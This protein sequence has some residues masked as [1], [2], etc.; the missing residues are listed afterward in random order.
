MLFISSS[1][2]TNHPQ[3]GL[4]STGILQRRNLH[5]ATP[6]YPEVIQK[7]RGRDRTP[8]NITGSPP[9]M[10]YS[11]INSQELFNQ[12]DVSN[13]T[14]VFHR[15]VKFTLT[16][17]ADLDLPGFHEKFEIIPSPCLGWKKH[18]HLDSQF[19]RPDKSNI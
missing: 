14:I 3:N 10:V 6:F 15:L 7:Q 13:S 12:D 19:D 2:L 5:L 9:V 8:L 1:D 16:D 4:R 18:R 17:Q 11:I